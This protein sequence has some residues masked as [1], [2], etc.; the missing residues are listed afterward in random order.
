MN[1]T[2][3]QLG[4]FNQ[5]SKIDNQQLVFYC[6]ESPPRSWERTRLTASASGPATEQPLAHSWPPPPKLSA[7]C[8][9]FSLPLLR[10]LTRY[11]PSGN[12][13]RNAATSTPPMER[14]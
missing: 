11:R 6:T 4:L 14:T 1:L 5:Q 13:R 9:T 8:A 2:R 10:R 7:T 3:R 12:S